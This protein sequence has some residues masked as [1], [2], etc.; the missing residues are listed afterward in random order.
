MGLLDGLTG[1]LGTKK[2]QKAPAF[3]TGN[4]LIDALVPM[5]LGGGKGGALGKLGGL[6]ALA[7][8]LAKTQGRGRSKAGGGGLGGMLGGLLG[9]GGG[10]AGGLGGLLSQ[11]QSRG[12]ASQAQSWVSTGPN[13]AIS[14]DDVEAG[15]GPDVVDQL[16]A[17]TGM[18][19]GDVTSQLTTI[20]PG[21]VDNLTPNGQVPDEA[22]LGGLLQHLDV[23]KILGNR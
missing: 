20:L 11:M 23:A 17:Q 13:E 12:F 21:L 19:R 18:A 14:A 7:G 9:G 5:L 6:G 1:M 15:L 22:Q 8:I 4:A 3:S 10:G 2:K 16:A